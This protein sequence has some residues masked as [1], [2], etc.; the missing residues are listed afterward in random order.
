MR[1]IVTYI[2]I[3]KLFIYFFV[4]VLILVNFGTGIDGTLNTATGE[5]E[6][7]KLRA[8]VSCKLF[9]AVQNLTS[10]IRFII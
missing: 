6:R 7:G 3:A 10:T 1:N 9:V 5:V 8:K 4:T 2:I